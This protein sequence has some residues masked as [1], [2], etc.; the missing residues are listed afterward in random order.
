MNM[1]C[2]CFFTLQLSALSVFFKQ[3]HRMNYVSWFICMMMK[4][5]YLHK[6]CYLFFLKELKIFHQIITSVAFF[7]ELYEHG[8]L[9]TTKNTKV[10]LSHDQLKVNEWFPQAA[11]IAEMANSLQLAA[12]MDPS[13]SGTGIWMYVV[14]FSFLHWSTLK[15]WNAESLIWWIP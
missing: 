14:F 10:C 1:F 2:L 4:M 9:T 7:L 5:W 8:I 15:M 12:K 13:R 3:L 6:F 11:H